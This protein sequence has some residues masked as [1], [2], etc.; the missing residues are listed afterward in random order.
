MAGLR[1]PS[2]T[3][4]ARSI[5]VSFAGPDIKKKMRGNLSEWGAGLETFDEKRS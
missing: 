1:T 2:A 5:G 4:R 3:S